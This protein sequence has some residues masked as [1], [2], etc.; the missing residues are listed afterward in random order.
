MK[1]NTTDR[2]RLK[3]L[4][5][6]LRSDKQTMTEELE[7]F[8]RFAELKLSQID[9]L[10]VFRIPEFPASIINK[11]DGMFI[12]GSSSVTVLNP[13]KYTFINNCVSLIRYCLEIDI[14][15]FASCFGHQLTAIALGGKVYRHH[16]KDFE[17][18]TI[19]ITLTQ[20]AENDI[21][22]RDVP[23]HFLGVSVHK[24]YTK[25]IPSGCTLLAYTNT[26]HHTYKVKNKRFWTFQFHP[27]VN[28]EILIK[29]LSLY[30][31][32]YT[33]NDEEL[34]KI[35]ASAKE[36]PVAN[37]LLKKFIDRVVI[38]SKITTD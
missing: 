38:K 3:L 6:Q 35:F 7:S 16:G 33:G 15:V 10:N 14:P 11:Y 19:P 26:C 22:Y 5:L 30:K 2:D 8:A 27:E 36:T 28:K 20:E 1:I 37:K 4:L 25:E 17:K 13:E 24:E 29:R 34:L 23:N 12:G 21:L 18:G 31:Q 32:Q 9:V